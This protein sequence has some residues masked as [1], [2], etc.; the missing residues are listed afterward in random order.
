M[1]SKHEITATLE[2]LRYENLDLRTITLGINL[3]NCVSSSIHQLVDR[4]KIRISRLAGALVKTC[5]Q[6]GNKYGVAVVNK[7]ISISPIAV[8]GA[9]FT[10]PELVSVAK[11]LDAVAEDVGVDFIGGYSALVEK[12]MATGDQALI[13][14][15]PHAMAET[16]RVCAS[17]NVASTRAGINMDAVLRMGKIVSETAELTADNDGIGCAKLVVFANIPQDIPFM[18]GA[19]LGIGEPDAVINVGVSGPGVVK[20]AVERAVKAE[21]GL[22]PGATFRGDKKNRL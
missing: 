19:Y 15:I 11:A 14:S 5:D 3:T 1:L 17:V 8:I 10:A 18:A 4:I 9:P 12:G 2:M 13:S 7:R 21:P 22:R 16:R 6:I 20:M